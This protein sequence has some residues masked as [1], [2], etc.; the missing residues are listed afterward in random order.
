MANIQP[1]LF[2]GLIAAVILFWYE[3]LKTRETLIQGCKRICESANLQFL[4]QSVALA[5]ISIKRDKRKQLRLLRKY[6]F[7]VSEDGANRMR[8]FINLSNNVLTDIYFEGP[9]GEVI[10][11]QTPSSLLH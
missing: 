1:L 11:Y 9:D 2:L 8:G 10:L 6:Q 4:D 5:S 3:S 7:E